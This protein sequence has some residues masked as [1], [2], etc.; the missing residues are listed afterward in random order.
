MRW[1][2][3][4]ALCSL[5]GRAELLPGQPCHHGTER[6]EGRPSTRQAPSK[7]PSQGFQCCRWWPSHVFSRCG[8]CNY[9]RS[10]PRDV[11]EGT[12]FPPCRQGRWCSA[13][14]G[15][16]QQAPRT[17]PRTTSLFSSAHVFPG[18]SRRTQPLGNRPGHRGGDGKVRAA[19]GR[20]PVSEGLLRAGL[21]DAA[22]GRPEGPPSVWGQRESLEGGGDETEPE[23]QVWPRWR[24]RQ[25][26]FLIGVEVRYPVIIS[27]NWKRWPQ[28][29]QMKDV[30][31]GANRARQIMLDTSLH[32][33]L[34]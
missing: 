29:I 20:G 9:R 24:K 34:S 2:H 1:Q 27:C 17:L 23:R 26:H 6:S 16:A 15:A 7:G 14:P 5:P 4:G 3:A 22:C 33:L 8:H 25:R 19:G 12:G 32:R 10:V 21:G 31:I 18:S 13:G 30:L 11:S 28:A